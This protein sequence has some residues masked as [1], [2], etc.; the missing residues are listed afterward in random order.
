MNQLEIRHALEEK[1]KTLGGKVTGAGFMTAP[2]F[3]MDFSFVLDGRD[4]S[5]KLVDSEEYR[6]AKEEEDMGEMEWAMLESYE[7]G[8]KVIENA[9]KDLSGLGYLISGIGFKDGN[10]EISCH[11]PKK[12]G[13]KEYPKTEYSSTGD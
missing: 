8:H 10:L 11:P 3:T 5:V 13:G 6:K 7:T 1:V 4:Y 2:P 12:E 9:M